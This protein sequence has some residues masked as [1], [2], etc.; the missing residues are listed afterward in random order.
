MNLQRLLLLAA[1][2][3]VLACG[4]KA[5]PEVISVPEKFGCFYEQDPESQ[6][7]GYELFYATDLENRAAMG[8][9]FTLAEFEN[10]FSP[11]QKVLDALDDLVVG[12]ALNQADI[13]GSSVED[14][15]RIFT[16]TDLEITPSTASETALDEYVERSHNA[17][18]DFLRFVGSN[19]CIAGLSEPDVRFQE[20]RE[21]MEIE[22]RTDQHIPII[23][24]NT[25]KFLTRATYEITIGNTV[26]E[27]KVFQFKKNIVVV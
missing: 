21:S 26:Y 4:T 16:Q 12:A 19:E 6:K 23:F 25:K 22:E 15:Q 5:E 18:D 3:A 14:I 11:S 13:D 2:S 10:S 1:S 8:N 27:S 17:V 24:G 20:A 7:Q 9:T